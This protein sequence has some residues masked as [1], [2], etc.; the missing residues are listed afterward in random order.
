MTSSLVHQCEQ[1]HAVNFHKSWGVSDLAES[2]SEYADL[3]E[4]Y[5]AVFL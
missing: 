4:V 2:P 5:E 1:T 3:P